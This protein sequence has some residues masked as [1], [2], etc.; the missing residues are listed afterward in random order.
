MDAAAAGLLSWLLPN[1]T[2]G[3]AVDPALVCIAFRGNLG[4]KEKAC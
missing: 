3:E 4:P 2:F 1:M